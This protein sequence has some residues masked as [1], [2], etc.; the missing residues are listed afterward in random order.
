MPDFICYF[1]NSSSCSL[2]LLQQKLNNSQPCDEM[3]F[4]FKNNSFIRLE[5]LENHIGASLCRVLYLNSCHCLRSLLWGV[6]PDQQKMEVISDA[7]RYKEPSV[8][9]EAQVD[10][11]KSVEKEGQNEEQTTPGL[12]SIDMNG[13][14]C[15]SSL[16]QRLMNVMMMMIYRRCWN[17]SP[18][19]IALHLPLNITRPKHITRNAESVFW[20]QWE[21]GVFLLL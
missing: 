12:H 11:K 13:V 4:A 2:Q 10:G 3:L 1:R 6:I 15:I 20:K 19:Y 21:I 5:Q 9:S 18:S 8:L 14:L 17:G 7:I 16:V